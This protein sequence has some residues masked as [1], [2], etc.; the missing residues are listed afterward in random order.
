M[1]N[2]LLH[3]RLELFPITTQVIW[4]ND[5]TRLTIA[6][7]DLVELA[8]QHA[9]PLYLYDRNTLDSAVDVYWRALQ[10]HYPAPFGLTYAGK[11]FLCTALVQWSQ[12]HNLWLDCTGAGEIAIALAGGAPRQH[13]LVHGVNKSQ[14]DLL[15]AFRHAATIVVDNLTELDRLAELAQVLPDKTP[16]LWLRLQPGLPVETHAYTQT[17]QADSKFGMDTHQAAHAVERCVREGLPLTGLH[18]HLG[19][20]FHDPTPLSRALQ[21][22]V[23]F[24][25]LQREQNGW[26][27]QVLCSGGGW[28][29]A[30]HEDELPHP[31]VDEY[32]CYIA[33]NIFTACRKHDL[34]LPRLQLE[35]GRSLVARAGVALYRAGA[36]KRTANRRWV[37]LDGGMADNI[38]PALYGARYSV[39]PVE[40]PGRQPSEPAW[41][42]GPFCESSD[43]LVDGLLLPEIQPGE[44]IAVPVSG[45]YQLSMGS[46]YNGALKPAVLW[47]EGGKAY[48]IQ[49]RQALDEL[50]QRD[51][52]LPNICLESARLKD[53]HQT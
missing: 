38:R 5:H 35:P 52:P 41:L 32:I 14:G 49:K 39:L 46:N 33:E 30:Y 47:L 1:L 44:L 6:G 28:G 51:Q 19:S 31:S 2:D 13:I 9:T 43:V 53:S 4:R 20:H 37:L 21:Q 12:T 24:I 3:N 8:E 36:V 16:N 15:S 26:A 40:D 23:E 10:R 27:P 25:A 45:A 17:G 11:A 29:V 7:C 48:L 22:A 50:L 34:P 42:G 18:F